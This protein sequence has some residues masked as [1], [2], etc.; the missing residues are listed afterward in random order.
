MQTSGAFYDPQLKEFVL[1]YDAVRQAD[2]PDG[3]LMTF[4]QDT[5]LAVA[6]NAAWDRAALERVAGASKR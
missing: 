5:Y 3:A 4:L 1:P 6:D 2:D